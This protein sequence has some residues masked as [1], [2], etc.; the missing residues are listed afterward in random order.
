MKKISLLLALILFLAACSNDMSMEPTASADFGPAIQAPPAPPAMLDEAVLFSASIA[1][2]DNWV[3]RSVLTPEPGGGTVSSEPSILPLQRLIIRTADIQLRTCE[4]HQT[5]TDIEQ[6]VSARGG[7]IENS[8]KWADP[9]WHDRSIQLWR[10][11]YTLRVPVGL[12][13][14]TNRELTELAQVQRFSTTSEDATMEFSD[15][16][17]RVRIREEE[18]RRV[19]LMLE[20]AT[21]IGDIINLEARVTSIR[22]AVDAYHRRMTEIDQL[23]GFSTITM[24]VY[25]V[26]EIEEVLYISDSFG[27]RLIAGF[28][29][30]LNF[31]TTVATGFAMFIAWVGLPAVL[32]GAVAFALYKVLRKIGVLRK[33]E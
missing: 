21:E 27:I 33:F 2:F 12:F 18:L 13:D 19:E 26:V 29:A 32:I 28:S 22:L 5:I 31:M 15:L 3:E 25:E 14:Q 20:N 6:I 17:S 4:F 16:A 1:E 9:A 24:T 8:R 11:E 10:V 7:F 30:S 23:A